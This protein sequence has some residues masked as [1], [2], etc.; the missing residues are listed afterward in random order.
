MNGMNKSLGKEPISKRDLKEEVEATR[1]YWHAFHQGLLDLS[2]AY[3]RAYLDFHQAPFLA[4][5]LEPKTCEFI[6]IAADAAVSH[7]FVPGLE[8]HIKMALQKGAT[9]REILEVIQLT[10]LAAHSSHAAGLPIL[11]E[12]LARA[13]HAPAYASRPLTPDEQAAK[14]SYIAATGHW[15][16][17]GDALFRFA[18]GFAKG[19]LAYGEIPY[20]EGP[21]SPKLKEFVCIAVYASP[22]APQ[23]G[24]LRQ[25]IRRALE[26]GAT[27]YEIADVLQLTSAI[28][29]HTCVA[30]VPALVSA[31]KEG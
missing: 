14:D 29:I 9:V 25:H 6:Y 8:M 7:L 1:G 21:L 20:R 31:A 5:N 16:E 26:V 18:P 28:A 19:F 17:G 30:A 13:G 2:P 12:E 10:M 22:V 24:P 15:P 4:G 27:A 3:L 11:A 23:P